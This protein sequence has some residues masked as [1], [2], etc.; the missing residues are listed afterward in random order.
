MTAGTFPTG[1]TQHRALH[2]LFKDDKI[3]ISADGSAPLSLPATLHLVDGGH[4]HFTTLYYTLLHFTTLY[5]TLHLVDGG[6]FHFELKDGGH[7]FTFGLDSYAFD[8]CQVDSNWVPLWRADPRGGGGKGE[9]AGPPN[10]D[11]LLCE[12][13]QLKLRP[14]LSPCWPR[15]ESAAAAAAGVGST[16]RRVLDQRLGGRVFLLTDSE[17]ELLRAAGGEAAAWSLPTCEIDATA[18]GSGGRVV[19]ALKPD[20]CDEC[21][22]K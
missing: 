3:S 22:A 10:A 8:T 9:P 15:A 19:T 12:H 4:F 18:A 11:A 17:F 1:T 16:K 21:A 20:F 2:R 5:Y 7:F 14:E 13:G 6:H